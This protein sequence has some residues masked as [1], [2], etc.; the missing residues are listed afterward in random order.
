MTE[1]MKEMATLLDEA[2]A[3]APR[4]KWNRLPP[5]LANVADPTVQSY[6]GDDG[7]WLMTVVSFD[8]EAQGFPPG[9]RGYDGAGSCK[10]CVIHFTRDLAERIFKIAEAACAKDAL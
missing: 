5:V 7:T 2:V 10:A 8:I 9:S 4:L 6:M 1:L 3:A